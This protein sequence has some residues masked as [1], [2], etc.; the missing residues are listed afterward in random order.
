MRE[1]DNQI[2]RRNAKHIQEIYSNPFDHG[3]QCPRY[4]FW[5]KHDKGKKEDRFFLVEP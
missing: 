3:M 4:W 5:K 2:S 1:C